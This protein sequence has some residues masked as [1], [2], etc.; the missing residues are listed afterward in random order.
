MTLP[1]VSTTKIARPMRNRQRVS[2]Q[3][4][5][6][7]TS[8]LDRHE[9]EKQVLERHRTDVNRHGAKRSR[10]GADVL[11]VS[12]RRDGQDATVTLDAYHTG[13]PQPCVRCV[14]GEHGLYAAEVLPHVI[15][16]A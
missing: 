10:L 16:D 9:L 7:M 15:E 13:R 4:L 11:D 12:A 8:L 1:I 3:A 14:I 6:H 5:Y 2:S